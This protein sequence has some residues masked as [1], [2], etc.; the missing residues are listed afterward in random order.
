MAFNVKGRYV[1]WYWY[2]HSVVKEK[3]GLN[4]TSQSETI[5]L[6]GGELIYSACS[7]CTCS[8]FPCKTLKVSGCGERV[9]F[10]RLTV[11][12]NERCYPLHVGICL[13]SSCT[14]S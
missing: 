13:C 14:S 12:R 1:C 6:S 10:S 8:C 5:S 7:A 9:L 3:S 2:M 11:T 4:K